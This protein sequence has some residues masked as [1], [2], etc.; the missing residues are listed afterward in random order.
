[1]EKKQTV[2][3]ALNWASSFLEKEGNEAEILLAHHLHCNRT[4][5]L[6]K[7]REP[8]PDD[9]LKKFKHDIIL[10]KKEGIPIQY[11]MGEEQFFGRPFK[12]DESVLIPRPETE[13][14]VQ[15]VIKK[16]DQRFSK[17]EQVH[18]CDIGT[19]SGAI[20]VT[21]KL[22]QPKVKMT[23]IDIS[24]AVLEVARQNAEM[25]HA[26][27]CF[28][29]GSFLSPAIERNRT[30]DVVVSNPPYIE[31]NTIDELDTVVREHEPRLALDG[32]EDGYHCYRRIIENLSSVL[33]AQAIV[34]FEVGDGQ[35]K[36]VSNLMKGKFPNAKVEITPDINHKERMVT[37]EIGFS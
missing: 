18:V 22:E 37:A 15:L 34:A 12:V 21:L 32:G 28:L 1:M 13:E 25:L 10:H 26:D 24:P 7:L 17:K 11:L 31:T 20:A 29:Q 8:C 33:N 16:I 6:M 27:I 3:E 4:G 23:A 19:G 5:M 9:V 14:L 2:I 35:A 36:T 30:F